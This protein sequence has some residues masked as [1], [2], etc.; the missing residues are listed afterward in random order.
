MTR[1]LLLLAAA[2]VFS[3]ALQAQQIQ[4]QLGDFDFKLGTDASRTMAHGLVSP[5]AVGAFHGGLDLSHPSGWYFGQYAPSMGLTPTSTLRLDSYLGYKRRFDDSLGFEAGLIHY[6]QPY[7]AGSD[8]YA[9][10][11]G[12]SV[13][14]SHFGGALRDNP[15]NRT[16]TLFADLGHLPLFDVDLTVKVAHHRLGTPFTI[17]DG[18]QVDAFSDWSL[19]LS[20]PWL[21]IDLNLIYSDSDLRGV[22]CDAYAGINRY[23][24]SMVTLKAQRSFF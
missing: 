18:S 22:G 16:G 24:E 17:G 6:S 23:C 3:P 11:G 13:L 9:L 15:N 2:L 7:L 10:Y 5:S 1:P 14:G 8:S 4:R 20:R 19:E 21:G 12:I